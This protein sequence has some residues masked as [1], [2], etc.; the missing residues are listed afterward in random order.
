MTGLR[1]KEG[2]REKEGGGDDEAE[3]AEKGR[4]GEEEKWYGKGKREC[5]C[6]FGRVCAR[7]RF[8][9]SVYVCLFPHP[10]GPSRDGS[11]CFCTQHLVLLTSA[12]NI[13]HAC[14]WL[15]IHARTNTTL[16]F[17][18]ISMWTFIIGEVSGE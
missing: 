18:S 3:I 13:T 10:Y 12:S 6:E 16:F 2:G 7:T 9:C 15:A 5:V 11:D 17:F 14:A 1:W 8:G 4:V